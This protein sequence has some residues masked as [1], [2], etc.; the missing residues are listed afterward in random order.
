[1]PPAAITRA[2]TL[3]LALPESHE[4]LAHGEPTFRVNNKQ[5][6]MFASKDNH[7]GAG[8]NALWCKAPPGKQQLMIADRPDRFFSPPY[9][10]PSGWVGVVLDGETDWSGLKDLVRIGYVMV[11]PKRLAD[12]MRLEYSA[13]STRV[14]GA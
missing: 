13:K 4:V 2:R 14:E 10:G 5:F 9:V 1:M 6:A 3:C 8:R 11:A 7:H 12:A